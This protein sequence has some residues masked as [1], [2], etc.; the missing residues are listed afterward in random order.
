MSI[1]R[2]L[3]VLLIVA[4][5]SQ[6]LAQTLTNTEQQQVIGYFSTGKPEQIFR[7]WQ[8]YRF[9]SVK[10]ETRYSLVK[11][12]DSNV[13]RANSNASASGLVKTVTI[14]TAKYP[15]LKWRW[16]VI[17]RPSANQDDRRADDDHAARLYII[18][19]APQPDESR[20]SRF[21]RQLSADNKEHTHAINYIWA[22]NSP[23]GSRLK[24]PYSSDVMMISVN[25]NNQDIGDWVEHQRNIRDDYQASFGRSPPPVSAVAI[26]TDS[27]NSSS[28]ATAFYGDIRFSA[29]KE[30]E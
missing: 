1:A 28:Q 19:N 7:D 2:F 29:E 20:W 11:D 14:D 24:N 3:S 9:K 6:A 30:M 21:W 17:R 5:T 8:P 16:K 22:N 18:F 4:S 27:D 25:N 13:I 10:K 12:N 23:I 15:I 26:M